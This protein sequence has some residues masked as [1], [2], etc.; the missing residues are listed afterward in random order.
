V[1]VKDLIARLSSED[2][3]AEVLLWEEIDQDDV[4]LA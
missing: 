2:P 3:E 1:K 4:P